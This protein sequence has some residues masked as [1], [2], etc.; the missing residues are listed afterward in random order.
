M[1]VKLGTYWLSSLAMLHG[2][3]AVTRVEVIQMEVNKV[4]ATGATRYNVDPNLS[5]REMTAIYRY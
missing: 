5:S 4:K 1:Q 3:Q 2:G